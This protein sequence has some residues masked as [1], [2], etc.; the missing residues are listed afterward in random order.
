MNTSI[1]VAFF[2]ICP[3][4]DL[5]KDQNRSPARC[6]TL[7][8]QPFWAKTRC[9]CLIFTRPKANFYCVSIQTLFWHI[10]SQ[11]KFPKSHF[12]QRVLIK[13][14]KRKSGKLIE[15]E[16]KILD[17]PNRKKYVSVPVFGAKGWNEVAAWPLK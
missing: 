11:N 17:P 14:N 7:I 9:L 13:W 6:V 5:S 8:S 1:L 12:L 15:P 4:L 2:F 10:L 3:R 16:R